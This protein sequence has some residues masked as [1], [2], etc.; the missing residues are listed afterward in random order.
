MTTTY[1]P[2]SD[3]PMSR[4]DDTAA[5][6]RSRP[7][8]NERTSRLCRFVN[9]TSMVMVAMLVLSGVVVTYSARRTEADIDAHHDRVAAVATANPSVL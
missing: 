6:G 8:P 7:T 1:R 9:R 4:S 5:G 3:D 2:P